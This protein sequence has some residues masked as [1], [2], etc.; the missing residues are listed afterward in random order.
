VR[1]GALDL[2]A[3]LGPTFPLDQVDAAVRASL[4]GEA[5]RVLVRMP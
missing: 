2:A 5:G 4:A 1:S 3:A